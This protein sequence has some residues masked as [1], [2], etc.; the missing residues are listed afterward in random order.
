[1]LIDTPGMRELGLVDADLS[2]TFADVEAIA[3]ECRF[4][5]CEHEREPGCAVREA[6][7]RGELEPARFAAYG[8]LQSELA[9]EHRR[10][11]ERAKQEQKQ[12]QRRFQREVN[13]V[14]RASPKR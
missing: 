7:S 13:R 1:M 4:G 9:Y 10:R 2:A 12:D 5:D 3:S 6:L 8:R 11:D 14:M